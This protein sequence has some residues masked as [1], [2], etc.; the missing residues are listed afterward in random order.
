MIAA[1]LATNENPF[2]RSDEKF[3]E[4]KAKLVSKETSGMSH[5]DLEEMLESNGREL[6]RRLL[7]DHLTLRAQRER[8]RGWKGPVRGT[9]GRPRS[10]RRRSERGLMS[11]FGPVRV[12]RTAYSAHGRTN[13]HPLD[14]VLNLPEELQ[15]H[16]I[17]RRVAVEVSKN[18][19][20]ETVRTISSTTGAQ[21][22]KRQVEQL[23]ALAAEDF[24]LFYR[25]REVASSSEV[26]HTGPIL[27]IT[28]DG[29]GVLVRKEDLR[30]ATRKEAERRRRRRR[31]AH[32]PRPEE[33]PNAKRMATVAAVYTIEPFV[34]KPEEIVRDLRP[35]N[36]KDRTQRPRPE[37]KRVWASLVQDPEV[38]IRQAFEEGLRRDPG[39]TKRWVALVDGNPDQ[40]RILRRTAK[41]Y[42]MRLTIVLDLIHVLEYLW[43]AASVFSPAHSTQAE[44]WVTERFAEV[45]RGKANY[46]AAGIHRSA[47]LRGLSCKQREASDD[48]ADYLLDY[49]EFLRYDKYLAR[50][51]PIATGVIEGA[52][53]HL[54]K[55]RM[56]L[57]GARWRL[58]RAEAVLRLRSLRSSGDFDHYW[59]FHLVQEHERNHAVHYAG[60]IPEDRTPSGSRPVLRRVK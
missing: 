21:V 15:S 2:A 8:E 25:T 13:L 3:S 27:V 28:V 55:D 12:E 20:D 44:S 26:D 16:G 23:A 42:H 52:C 31:R 49:Q 19:F 7:Q 4:L 24:D 18:S 43:K 56:D 38:V 50:G 32:E 29:K 39:Q 46:V 51:L 10:Y 41:R 33:R 57:T 48:C 58:G 40:I 34:R 37:R 36:V 5:G 47:T 22:G 17:R 53:R 6:L 35:G 60:V 45:L 14:A 1:Q 54:I 59:R 9:D 30:E 11:V